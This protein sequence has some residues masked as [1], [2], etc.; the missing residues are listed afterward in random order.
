LG[1]VGGFKD[2]VHS[3]DRHVPKWRTGKPVCCGNVR[4]WYRVGPL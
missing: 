4:L 1:A 2:S 3:F